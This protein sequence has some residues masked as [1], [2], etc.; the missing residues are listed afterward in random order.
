ML[1]FNLNLD[2]KSNFCVF[3]NK[4][5]NYDYARY[6]ELS[7]MNDNLKYCNNVI[8][9]ILKSQK[10][11]DT[12]STR[13]TETQD[14]FEELLSPRVITQTRS[15]LPIY[16]NNNGRDE[17]ENEPGTASY[18]DS[19]DYRFPWHSTQLEFD[20]NNGQCLN[21]TEDSQYCK[22]E[23][24]LINSSGSS[25]NVSDVQTDSSNDS[26]CI[27]YRKKADNDDDSE[28]E[29][30][31]ACCL[32]YNALHKGDLTVHVSDR[33]HI[34]HDSGADYV[35]VKHIK[36]EKCGYIPRICI[37]NVNKFLADLN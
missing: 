10:L 11:T 27:N 34:I 14:N 25:P 15:R 24:K 5:S 9:E 2:F 1:I 37:L 20:H 23:I 29:T 13:N 28:I 31:Y 6:D 3:L 36:T 35:L 7:S 33:I 16:Y 22:T 32:N 30:I 8:E 4:D 17:D 18:S 21:T 19:C 12:C 26:T